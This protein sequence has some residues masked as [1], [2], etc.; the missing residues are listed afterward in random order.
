MK[1]HSLLYR[2]CQP[3]LSLV[4]KQ[5]ELGPSKKCCD[6]LRQA[7]IC[8]FILFSCHKLSGDVADDSQKTNCFDFFQSSPTVADEL[9]MTVFIGLKVSAI[10][11]DSR[12]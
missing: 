6:D 7:A 11:A 1:H 12:R 2:F 9:R 4:G 10:V 5:R 8:V 3:F